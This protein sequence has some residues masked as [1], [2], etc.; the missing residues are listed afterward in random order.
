MNVILLMEFFEFF[1]FPFYTDYI[2]YFYQN[3]PT[4]LNL[5][6]IKPY[7]NNHSFFTDFMINSK[8]GFCILRENLL[9]K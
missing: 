3:E 7:V 2:D 9:K 6:T 1:D 4:I 5:S 8:E